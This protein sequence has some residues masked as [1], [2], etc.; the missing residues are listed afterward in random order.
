MTSK[1]SLKSIETPSFSNLKSSN[2]NF[3]KLTTQQPLSLSPTIISD[4]SICNPS[5][6]KGENTLSNLKIDNDNE[7]W[8]PKNP[9]HQT[10]IY[11][12]IGENMECSAKGQIL[13]GIYE[14]LEDIQNSSEI[15]LTV[16]DI[17]KIGKKKVEL[18]SLNQPLSV[19]KDSVD[20]VQRY[21]SE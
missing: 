8:Q 6:F 16:N 18:I 10:K 11:S 12:E 3:N 14:D 15:K 19:N 13:L 20:K 1:L 21:Y 7:I 5:S 2:T 4:S 9:I 17:I